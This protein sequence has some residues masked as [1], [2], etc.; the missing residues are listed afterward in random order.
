M[1]QYL[2][3]RVLDVMRLHSL[4]EVPYSVYTTTSHSE[5]G[6]PD[7]SDPTDL[8]RIK[9]TRAEAQA[10]KRRLS[11][12]D[13]KRAK[14]VA[15]FQWF[16]ARSKSITD[17]IPTVDIDSVHELIDAYFPNGEIEW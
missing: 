15:H 17:E 5:E 13:K 8:Y 10:F 16:D 14:F 6:L 3:P 4:R 11:N 12:D 7:I 1:R 9:P 2:P